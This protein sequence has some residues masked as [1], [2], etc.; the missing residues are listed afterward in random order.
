MN[1][2]WTRSL[3]SHQQMKNKLDQ[4][5]ASR[6]HRSYKSDQSAASGWRWSGSEPEAGRRGKQR[7][8]HQ[9]TTAD[10]VKRQTPFY[11]SITTQNKD[12][13]HLVLGSISTSS[14]TVWL[15]GVTVRT[16]DIRSRGRG[17][18]SRLGR[19]QVVTTWMGHCLRTG[20]PSQYITTP[21]STQP[22]IHPR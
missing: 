13:N 14:I 2:T 11:S 17:F 18:D 5:P 20:K 10:I 8:A 12:E 3:T 19:Y 16:L 7:T 4:S 22:S 9:S 21:R 1:S 6:R 15:G